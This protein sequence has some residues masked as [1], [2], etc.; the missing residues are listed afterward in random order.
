MSSVE[1]CPAEAMELTRAHAAVEAGHREDAWTMVL[2]H[3]PEGSAVARSVVE[4]CEQALRLWHA[5]RDGVAERMGLRRE[6]A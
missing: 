4:T 6:A 1:K 3:T 5:Y 2:D